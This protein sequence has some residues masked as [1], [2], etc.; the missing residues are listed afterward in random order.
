M[1][2]SAGNQ[3]FVAAPQGLKGD[4]DAICVLPQ[5][6]KTFARGGNPAQIAGFA[7]D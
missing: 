4:S 2:K 5:T 3:G 6:A 7:L 1:A